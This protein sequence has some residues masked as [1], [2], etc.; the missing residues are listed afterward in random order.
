MTN[1]EIKRKIVSVQETVKITKAMYSIS[2]AKMIAAKGA[3]SAAKEYLDVYRRI[4]DAA[5]ASFPKSEFFSRRG[6]RIGFLVIAGDKGLCGDHNA[7]VIERAREAIDRVSEK[8]IFTVGSITQETFK[9]AGYEVDMEYL[10]SSASYSSAA[11]IAD[12]MLFLYENDM[13]DVINVVYTDA[14]RHEVKITTLL[15]LE[16]GK[17]KT[18]LEPCNEASLR[19]CVR[20]R[21]IASLLYLLLSASLAEHT[22]R[23]RIMSGSTDNAEKMIAELTA[24][25]N[26]AR[27]ESITRAM[28][29]G[30]ST[31]RSV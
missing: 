12:D 29:D 28:Q 2:V 7:Q 8:Y 25:Y 1:R 5:S 26:R 20:E 21:L 6:D 15:P 3:L 30:Y 22:A 11:A 14:E 9:K 4:S 16:A 10:R 24:K 23:A 17:E 18:E 27:Q 19:T 31:D 13:L